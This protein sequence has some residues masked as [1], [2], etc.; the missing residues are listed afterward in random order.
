MMILLSDEKA[1]VIG[2]YYPFL[3]EFTTKPGIIP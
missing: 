3:Y 2:Q 1:W